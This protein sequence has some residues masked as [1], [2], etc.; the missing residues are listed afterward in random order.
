MRKKK[1]AESLTPEQLL[2]RID[3]LQGRVRKLEGQVPAVALEASNASDM[4]RTAAWGAQFALLVTYELLD[5]HPRRAAALERARWKF[6]AQ[7]TAEGLQPDFAC[8][9]AAEYVALL[10]AGVPNLVADAGAPISP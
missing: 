10:E 1:A 9:M 5:G 4:M 6:E 3:L 2:Y 7:L 8:T